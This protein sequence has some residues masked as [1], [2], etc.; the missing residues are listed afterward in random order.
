[1]KMYVRIKAPFAAFRPMTAGWFRPTAAMVTPSA[2]YGLLLNFAAIDSRVKETDPDHDGSTPA[3]LTRS[4][5]PQ[6]QIALGIPADAQT[7]LQQTVLQQLHN[8]PVGASGMPKEM[9]MGNKNNITPVKR[10][11]LSE[12]DFVV[13]I[14]TDEDFCQRIKDGVQ[15]KHNQQRYGLPFLG[16][17]SFLIDL[18]KTMATPP[19]TRWYEQMTDERVKKRRLN[20]ATRLTTF[21]DRSGFSGTKSALFMP[22][23][24]PIESP[25]DLA[26]V[27]VG[28]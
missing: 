18:V 11:Y 16:D 19:P 15:G 27:E 3:S 21:I 24:D 17:N 26:W 13:G 22:M 1:M 7:P 9:T 6:A 2:A 25:T 23:L 28:R 14:E 5:L 4:G 10:E 20:D 8:Y 12:L